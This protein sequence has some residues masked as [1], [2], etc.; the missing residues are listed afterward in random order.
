M[1]F[2]FFVLTDTGFRFLVFL[3]NAQ[4]DKERLRIPFDRVT[5]VK[6][7]SLSYLISAYGYYA[8]AFAMF[9]DSYG[10]FHCVSL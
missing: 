7:L 10:R 6:P 1:R 8:S 9:R 3:M 4:S 5:G 2:D